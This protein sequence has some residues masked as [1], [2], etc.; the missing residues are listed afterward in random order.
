[1]KSLPGRKRQLRSTLGSSERTAGGGLFGVSQ[2]A[3]AAKTREI[4][5]IY[6]I[7]QLDPRW[8]LPS[9]L[10]ENPLVWMIPVN[11][12]VV[13]IRM[14]PRE[15]QEQ[16]YQLGLIPLVPGTGSA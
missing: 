12:V 7:V 3:C 1:V 5:R 13:D 10:A 8:C 9:K 14:M 4:R 6:D 2:N 11:G 15:F 16:A